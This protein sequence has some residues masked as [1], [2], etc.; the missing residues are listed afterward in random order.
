MLASQATRLGEAAEVC[1]WNRFATNEIQRSLRPELAGIHDHGGHGDF[2][3]L[4]K[5][6]LIDTL[7]QSY[8][9]NNQC[10]KNCCAD[11]S[12]AH[13]ISSHFLELSLTLSRQ[14]KI[15]QRYAL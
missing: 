5:R 3:G 13:R 8:G 14:Q 12:S 10:A 2:G 9:A 1:H 7:R 6:I 11:H 15:G 4:H